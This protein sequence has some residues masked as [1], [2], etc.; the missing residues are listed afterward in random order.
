MYILVMQVSFSPIKFNQHILGPSLSQYSIGGFLD[1]PF[2]TM[3]IIS[4][5]EMAT[6][7]RLHVTS[8]TLAAGNRCL[9]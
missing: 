2:F 7:D 3:Q 8:V 5:T 4:T 6:L 1:F 9:S